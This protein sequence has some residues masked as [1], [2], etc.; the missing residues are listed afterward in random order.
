MTGDRLYLLAADALLVLHTLL[1]LFIVGGLVVIYLGHWR[2]WDWVRTLWFSLLHLV[3]ISIVVLQSWLGAIC[4]L[5]RWEM[6][7]RRLAG[8]ATYSGS[9]IQHWLHELL[10][11]QAPGWV[12]TLLYTLFGALVLASWFI[13]PPR[14]N[15]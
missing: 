5:T 4:P 8:N 14:R 11:F 13:V 15:R 7:L 2:S 6:A 12:F 3:A 9:F 10:Y 1:V